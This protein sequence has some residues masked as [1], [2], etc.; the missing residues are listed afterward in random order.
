MNRFSAIIITTF[1]T[2]SMFLA[3]GCS[4]KHETASAHA[5]EAHDDHEHGHE[6]E[7]V[8]F[9]AKKGLSI[10]KETAEFIGLELADVEERTVKATMEFGA[11]VYRAASEA[12]YASAKPMAAAATLATAFVGKEVAQHLKQGQ[13]ITGIISDGKTLSGRIT[14]VNRSFE[15][16][17]GQAEVL[18]ALN[19]PDASLK[20]GAFVTV[21][22]PNGSDKTVVSIPKSAILKTTEG[23]FAYTVS[24]EHFVRASIKLGSI[25]ENFA[26]VTDGLYA[27]DQ[28][29]IKPVMTLWMAELQAIRGGKACAD[30]H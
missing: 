15:K 6:E 5:E 26:E 14:E 4:P 12:Q 30:G 20:R 9:L 8:T 10:P 16:T 2:L 7:G 21:Q 24:G 29:V 11:Q 25:N 17:S 19:D 3:T 18:L 22:V 23:Y 28:I 13:E 27:G 1:A